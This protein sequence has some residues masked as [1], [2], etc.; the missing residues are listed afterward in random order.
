LLNTGAGR[1]LLQAI[2]TS[3]VQLFKKKVLDK[4]DEKKR[5]DLDAVFDIVHGEI[6]AELE[7]GK[8]KPTDLV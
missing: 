1:A 4:L 5:E 3:L 7:Y 8:L 6:H 2:V